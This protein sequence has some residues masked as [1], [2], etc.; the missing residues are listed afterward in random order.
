MSEHPINSL[1]DTTMKK[2]KE[3]VDDTIKNIRDR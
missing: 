3:L 2:I 1:M